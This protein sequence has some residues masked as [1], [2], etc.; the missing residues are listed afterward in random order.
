MGID[1][2]GYSNVNMENI[3]YEY[4]PKKKPIKLNSSEQFLFSFYD[5]KN[6]IQ[7]YEYIMTPKIEE[8]VNNIRNDENVIDIDFDNSIIVKKT[9]NTK[10]KYMYSSYGNYNELIQKME[11]IIGRK[12]YYNIPIVDGG[13]ICN[14]NK[15]KNLH[16]DLLMINVHKDKLGELKDKFTAYLNIIELSLDNGCV[17]SF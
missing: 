8:W 5:I 13:I 3:P 15:L 2:Y 12:L 1:I 6:N 14:K 7:D 17:Y 16:D 11:N 9:D 10:F 4:I